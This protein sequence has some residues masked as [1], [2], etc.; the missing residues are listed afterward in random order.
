MEIFTRPLR[1][2]DRVGRGTEAFPLQSPQ[3]FPLIIGYGNPGASGIPERENQLK[4]IS[5]E[6][7][8]STR[9]SLIT[10]VPLLM[11][12]STFLNLLDFYGFL[13][14][15]YRYTGEPQIVLGLRTADGP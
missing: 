14:I 12:S 3:W 1:R 8:N 7:Q 5:W 9:I 6:N 4:N 10:S 13:W 2:G 11:L 15:I